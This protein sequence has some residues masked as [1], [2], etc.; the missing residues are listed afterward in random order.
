MGG[1]TEEASPGRGRRDKEG[2]G[3]YPGKERVKTFQAEE[4]AQA[5]A[6][7]EAGRRAV[8]GWEGQAPDEDSFSAH[9][10]TLGVRPKAG[11]WA[12]SVEE[13]T[14]PS[15]LGHAAIAS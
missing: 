5:K 4:R 11:A 12:D 13:G 1:C 9:A 2:C 8:T 15:R 3:S 10:F 14:R 7:R 6:G